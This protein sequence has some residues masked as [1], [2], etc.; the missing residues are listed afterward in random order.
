M[1]KNLN[2]IRLLTVCFAVVSTLAVVVLL[3]CSKITFVYTDLG[4]V[5]YF[6]AIF[7]V[8][9][10][11]CWKR[12]MLRLA[13]PLEAIALGVLMAMPILAST[14]L[15]ASLNR[16]LMDE[17]LVWTDAAIGFNWLTFI[18]FV[19][20]WPALAHSLNNAYSTFLV[21]LFLLPLI[22]GATGRYERCYTMVLSYAVIC[23]VSSIVSIWFPALGTYAVYGVQQDQLHNINAHFGFYFLDHF[24]AVR[25]EAQFVLS[26][27]TAKGIITFPSV[28]AAVALLCAWAAWDLRLPAR[29]FFLALNILMAVAAITHGNHYLVDVIAGLAIAAISILGVTATVSVL[30]RLIWPSWHGLSVADT[31][32]NEVGRRTSRRRRF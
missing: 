7:F 25:S 8:P 6:F 16:P 21:Q 24:N 19:D 27:L 17:A 26:P 28:H 9:S 10:L 15:A 22:L 13:A 23:Y 2:E 3:Q 4:K 12:G 5:G 32:K 14:Y 11:Y 1:D 20:S 29:L 18:G 30:S 31:K